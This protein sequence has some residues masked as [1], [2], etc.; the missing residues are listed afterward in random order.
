MSTNTATIKNP[1][2]SVKPSKKLVEYIKGIDVTGG[3]PLGISNI[4]F[5]NPV[6]ST[7]A[8]H[9]KIDYLLTPD[10]TEFIKTLS[11]DTE[12]TCTKLPLGS[13]LD[14]NTDK[15]LTLQD[16]HWLYGYINKKNENNETKVY[17][18]ELIEG[19]EIILPKNQEIPRNPELESRCKKLR[20]QQQNKNYHD[21]TKNV[22]NIR[23][24]YPE[25]TLAF[26]S[27]CK[28]IYLLKEY[29][30]FS[31]VGSILF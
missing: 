31:I 3:I 11:S 14:T 16:L 5:K 1:S 24:K 17:L 25:D 28:T 18:H 8:E 13:S 9:I 6:K 30:I 15:L 22:D 29:K 27:K 12:N 20:A 7:N 23:K 2:I 10:D 4:I 26:Q 19:S 21:M